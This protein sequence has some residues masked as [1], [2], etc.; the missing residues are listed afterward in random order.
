LKSLSHLALQLKLAALIFLQL[1]F[2]LPPNTSNQAFAEFLLPSFG[3][4]IQAFLGLL[5][6]SFD[7]PIQAFLGLLIPSSDATIQAFLGLLIPSSDAPI[8]AFLW[9]FHFFSFHLHEPPRFLQ[10]GSS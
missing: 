3:A 2:S 6:P 9:L 1:P 5:I 10:K 4:P 8:Q 7:A